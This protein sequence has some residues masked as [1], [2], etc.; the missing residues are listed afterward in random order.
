M[1]EL[2]IGEEGGYNRTI[3]VETRRA[4]ER[5]VLMSEKIK[6]GR[7]REE[8][9]HP[10]FLGRLL[11]RA[12]PAALVLAV[13]VPTA[14]AIG[15]EASLSQ[16]RAELDRLQ[17]SSAAA[18]GNF[19]AGDGGVWQRPEPGGTDGSA[20]PSQETEPAE[21]SVRD[22]GPEVPAYQALY[23]EL[24][25][26]EH[27][28]NTVNK[29]K[30]CYLTFD[31]GPSA[32]TPEVLEI[33]ERYGVKATFFVVGKDTEQ[34]RQWMK[35]IVD[36]GHTIGVHSYTHTYRKIYASVEAYLEDFAKEYHIIEEA[37]GVA[38]QIFRFPG[39]SINAYNG[40]I[41][42]EIVAEMTRRGFVYFDWNRSNGDA[43]RKPPAAAVLAQNA[44]DRLGA[45]SR[46]VVLM[47][48]SKGHAT[49]VAALPAIIEGYRNA[50]YTLEALTPEVRPIV[51]AYPNP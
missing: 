2:A 35:Q 15:L 23:P 51:Y 39:G 30:V 12:V 7:S 26:G 46:V 27:E 19:L 36:A 34:S 37:T 24:Y 18:A 11:R 38:P 47:H 28:W 1:I 31:D 42:Q 5:V 44:L 4:R 20:A 50:G 40:H 48:D 21:D 3:N 10:F 45:S 6:A 8:K 9:K 33:L 32:R 22:P 17:E 14:L 25:A 13:L 16:T 29:K 41:Y 49:T 43:V